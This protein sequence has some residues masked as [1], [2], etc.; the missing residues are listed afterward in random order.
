MRRVHEYFKGGGFLVWDK[1]D[2]P[3]KVTLEE[4]PVYKSEQDAIDSG[5]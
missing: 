5:F 2:K 3:I 1:N 4:H